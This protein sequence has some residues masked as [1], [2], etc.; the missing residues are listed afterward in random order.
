MPHTPSLAP[1]DASGH[2]E[3]GPVARHALADAKAAIDAGTGMSGTAMERA[4]RDGAIAARSPHARL[5]GVERP[6]DE[7][8]NTFALW[9]ADGARSHASLGALRSPV[10]A[11]RLHLAADG[12]AAPLGRY[13]RATVGAAAAGGTV[14]SRA[15]IGPGAARARACARAR[16]GRS[17]P[18]GRAPPRGRQPS[19]ACAPPRAGVLDAPGLPSTALSAA[20]NSRRRRHAGAR[21]GRG[22]DRGDSACLRRPA[23]RRRD[24]QSPLRTLAAEVRRETAKGG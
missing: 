22:P 16:V 14:R 18:G 12:R 5:V 8:P 6:G 3:M 1:A 7:E 17:T 11:V 23:R 19:A 21:A 20:M 4:L 15:G 9:E 13:R 2:V 24:G 10:H